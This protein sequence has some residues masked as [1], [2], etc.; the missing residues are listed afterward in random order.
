MNIT[1]F[2]IEGLH[3]SKDYELRFIENRLILVSDNG[4]GKTTIVNIFY[5][6]LS[7]QWNKLLEYNFRKI[8]CIIN[9]EKIEFT[10]E[11]F[12]NLLQK[13]SKFKHRFSPTTLSKLNQ[14]SDILNSGEIFNMSNK[15]IELISEKFDIPSRVIKE[16]IFEVYE[17]KENIDN[18]NN[19]K[20]I[21]SKLNS[22]LKDIKIIYLPTYRRIEKD[23]INILPHLE[24]SIKDYEIQTRRFSSKEENYMELVE[25]G[26]ND[27]QRKIERRCIELKNYFY[28]KLN[29]N[30]IGSY[31]DDILNKSYNDFD[32]KKIS[33]IDEEALNY[34]LK[35]LDD[36]VISKDGKNKL[37]EFV[38]S[39]QLNYSN[40]NIEDK[41]NAHFVWKLFQIYDFQ[42]KEESD[43]LKLINI[44]NEYLG[45]D[46]ELVYNKDEF[47]VEIILNQEI[48]YKNS[49]RQLFLDSDFI[50]EEKVNRIEF[51]DLS[52]GEKQ[53]ISLF[54]HLVLSDKDYFI[55]ID[56]PELSLSVPW[57]EKLLNDILE[58][59]KC[60]GLLAVTH[61]PFIF[62]NNLR[63]YTR[64]LE[65]FKR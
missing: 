25:F 21:E 2:T 30:L 4:A 32:F 58:L 49:I 39:L 61:S 13:D 29:T 20:L 23:L 24:R 22:I 63:Q 6:F 34:I 62:Q 26:M 52:S 19:I 45:N 48:N 37:R 59:S 50:K 51:R 1:N 38:Q 31:L 36:S 10:K 44:C 18:H 17:K 5:Y 53:I 27:I 64:S 9:D 15:E 3:N 57:Q 7:K 43:I 47:K 12:Q 16:Y 42:Q 41:I 46:K 56:E 14:I 11:F 35:R 40:N 55:I 65:E 54:T 33:Q 28:D 60:R 8:K